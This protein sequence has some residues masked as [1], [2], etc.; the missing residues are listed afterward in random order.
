MA[1]R[2]SFDSPTRRAQRLYQL[3]YLKR[4]LGAPSR[5]RTCARSSCGPQRRARG[6][7]LLDYSTAG[8]PELSGDIPILYRGLKNWWMCGES[9]PNGP[10]IGW[11]LC[12][13][14]PTATHRACAIFLIH[15]HILVPDTGFEP[16]RPLRKRQGLSLLC[17]PFHH[18][19][20]DLL[21][22]WC[23]ER[24]LNSQSFRHELL[25]LACIPIPPPTQ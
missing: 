4:K 20:R 24:D 13:D 18:P 9:N 15:T 8:N 16:V 17:L 19:G 21:K 3:S 1:L 14:A 10:R 22:F 7:A 12:V 25:R 6:V 23:V 11:L 5:I 2:G